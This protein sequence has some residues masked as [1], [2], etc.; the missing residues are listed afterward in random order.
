MLL[1]PE[2]DFRP[3]HPVFLSL[4]GDPGLDQAMPYLV[5]RI[6]GQVKESL[7]DLARLQRLLLASQALA[8]NRSNNLGAYLPQLLPALMTCLLAAKVGQTRATGH[9]H[10]S[11]LC[12]H[13][14]CCFTCPPATCLAQQVCRKARVPVALCS[15]C[16]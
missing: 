6:A 8:L 1:L 15:R 11:M 12:P 2:A 9:L 5:A 7:A 10:L 16:I 14:L 13:V 4:A 3:A